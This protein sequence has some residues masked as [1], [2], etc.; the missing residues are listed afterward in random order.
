MMFHNNN[1]SSSSSRS[2]LTGAAVS[3][4]LMWATTRTEA[5]AGPSVLP[6]A[7]DF[8]STGPTAAVSAPPPAA[9][10]PVQSEWA[11]LLHTFQD[12]SKRTAGTLIRKKAKMKRKADQLQSVLCVARSS[13]AQGGGAAVG[14]GDKSLLLTAEEEIEYAYRIRAYKTASKLRNELVEHVDGIYV[15]P[16]DDVWAAALGTTAADLHRITE[17]GRQARAAI[18]SANTGLV[19]KTAHYYYTSLKKA[20]EAQKGMGTILSKADMIQEGH[21]GLMEAAERF[22]PDKGFR[23]GT[24]AM[25]WVRQRILKSIS[26]TSR[27]IRLPVYVHGILNKVRKAKAILYGTLGRDPTVSEI[28]QYL[29]ISETRLNQFTE[30]GRNVMSLER[31]IKVDL[32]SSSSSSR[33]NTL[34]DTIASDAPTAEDHMNHDSLK[35]D[36]RSVLESELDQAERDVLMYRFGFHD[37]APKSIAETAAL[38]NISR[39][40]ARLLEAHAMNKL[41]HPKTHHKLREYA[42]KGFSS[43]T[44]TRNRPHGAAAAA[45]GYDFP[46]GPLQYQ[47]YS[48]D[49][50]MHDDDD[51][52]DDDNNQDNTSTD[53][54]TPRPDRLWFF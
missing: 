22:N 18:V 44:T 32:M 37:N 43:T 16:T 12:S 53:N 45:A 50:T 14:A 27:V 5:F 33:E 24:Y 29:G 40:R 9:P 23:F 35:N 49:N 11:S 17:E 1:S 10:T 20:T 2:M 19:V 51:D 6:A 48:D 46:T 28:A 31:P 41:R 52:D 34:L 3:L 15:H 21:L 38:L 26:D 36:I 30:S 7:A 47:R 25:Y 42:P 13:S 39:D 54:T 8:P 4:C